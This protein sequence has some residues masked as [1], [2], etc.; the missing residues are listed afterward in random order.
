MK[1]LMSDS[2]HDSLHVYRVLYMAMNIAETEK[3]ADKDVL[4]TA[5]LL[6]DIG[7]ALQFEDPSLCHAKEGARMA[8]DWLT[9]KGWDEAFSA[10][11]RDCIL[12]HRFRGDHPP[13]TL[14]AKILSDADNLDSTG[15]LSAARSFFYSAEAGGPIYLLAEDG[16]VLTDPVDDNITFAQEYTFKLHK[17]HKRF[18]TRRGK[19][20]AEERHVILDQYYEAFLREANEAH[21]G[22]RQLLE[23]VLD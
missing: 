12:S 10:H 11:V 5:A 14:E 17:V 13:E 7:R 3:S 6:H 21:K 2:A 1:S 19:E 4:I 20:L 15:A 8:Y 16:G 23:R 18:Y 9:S 22:G